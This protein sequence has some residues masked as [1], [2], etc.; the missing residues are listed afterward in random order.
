MTE[1][2]VPYCGGE[3]GCGEFSCGEFNCGEFNCG[4]AEFLEKKSRFI[5]RVWLCSSEEEALRH[6]AEMQ[7]KHWDATH[8]V[9]A[10][11]I[12]ETGVTRFSDD[13]EPQGTAGLPVLDVFRKEG[14][15]NFLCVVTRYFGGTLLGTG[16]LVR[17][18]AHAAKLGLEAAGIAVMQPVKIYGFTCSYPL[19]ERIKLEI[20]AFGGQIDDITYGAEIDIRMHLPEQSALRFEARLTELSAGKM[21]MEA[22]GTDYLPVKRVTV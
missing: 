21:R 10:Y 6:I 22:L 5:G 9:Y 20:E 17:A 16:G 4:E 2:L 3:S 19:L 8:N 14:I 11:S 7:K 13:G 18:Y 12:R 15:T 1:Y